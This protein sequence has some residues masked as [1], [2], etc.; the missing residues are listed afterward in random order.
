ME[1][2]KLLKILENPVASR[3]VN[4]LNSPCY[5]LLTTYDFHRNVDVESAKTK[6]RQKFKELWDG[7][8][9]MPVV[10]SPIGFHKEICYLHNPLKKPKIRIETIED[11]YIAGRDCDDALH[12]G[13]MEGEGVT[14]VLE[15]V[16]LDSDTLKQRDM[17]DFI[18]AIPLIED[19][20]IREE[21]KKIIFREGLAYK[22]ER[23][24]KEK[25]GF[26]V[27]SY[28]TIVNQI[29]GN[30]PPS[31]SRISYPSWIIQSNPSWEDLDNF[32]SKA[33]RYVANYLSY[34]DFLD[35]ELIKDTG[36]GL[37]EKR[38]NFPRQYFYFPRLN[39][40][41]HKCLLENDG[42]VTQ[43]RKSINRNKRMIRKYRKQSL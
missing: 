1:K 16:V 6:T 29:G 23:E 3:I 25:Y 8:T 43:L 33:E 31:Y 7:K 34:I 39:S 27:F 41:E 21:M 28:T 15:R 40:S 32:L 4:T 5:V 26:F 12:H 37:V 22:I 36:V 2:E 30:S 19:E 11:S 24:L 20:K 10:S 42:A 17:S 14:G 35:Q 38:K 18:Q 9:V 13:F